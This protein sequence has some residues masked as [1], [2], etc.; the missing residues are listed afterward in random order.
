[1]QLDFRLLPMT[2]LRTKPGEILDRVADKGEAFLI[3]RNGTRMA[4]L[5]PL[6]VFLPD[7]SPT[8]IA[9]EVEELEKAGE[10]PRTTV[11]AEREM[12]FRFPRLPRASNQA[13]GEEGLAAPYEITVVLPRGYP[14]TCP[15]LY[16][17]AL[18]E[19]APHRWSDGALC[20]F[21]VMSIWNPGKHS[22]AFALGLARSWL[23]SYETWSNTGQWPQAGDGE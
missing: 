23:K 8:R 18:K 6:W 3:E 1:M 22:V 9:D 20:V 15:R 11:T 14:N 16:A 10:S 19:S 13:V 7:I 21:G 5:V 12:A 2:E 4:C 17:T